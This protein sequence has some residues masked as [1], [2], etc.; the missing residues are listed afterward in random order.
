MRWPGASL[1]PL[2]AAA[3]LWW[4]GPSA[5]GAT[6]PKRGIASGHYLSSRPAVL[7]RLDASWAYDWSATAPPNRAGPPWVPM[8]WGAGSVKPSVI[9][10]LQAARRSGRARELLG[11]N[12]PD[13]ASQS[14]LSPGRAASLW[15]QLERTGLRLGSPA[16]AVPGDGWLARF[17]GLARARHLRVDFIALHYYQ[18]FT[19]PAAV[20]ALRR[21]LVAIHRQYGKPIWITEIGA[22]DIRRFHEPME[23]TP[24]PGRA[25]AYLRQL[26][27]MLDALP[28]VQRYAWFI[29]DCWSDSACGPY[30]S[31]LTRSGRPTRLGLAFESTS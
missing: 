9:A 21:Q 20:A 17:M 24:T 3:A 2:V 6:H 11:F 1:W 23:H 18:D 31:L 27:A 13:S 4:V 19:N 12:E 8:I 16:P 30:S 29:D 22:L 26:F 15:P 10:S 5:L 25:V 7:T 14:N 28:F